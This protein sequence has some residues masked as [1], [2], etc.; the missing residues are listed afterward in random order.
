MTDVRMIVYESLLEIE[1]GQNI[2]DVG[3]GTLDKHAY[4]DKQ[5]R[6]FMHCLFEG[7]IDKKITLDYVIDSVSKMPVSKM[8][9]PVK[10]L[11]RMGAYQ[12]LFM[13]SVPDRASCNET[14]AIARKKHLDSL[15]GFINGVLRSICRMEGQ[16]TYPDKVRDTKRYLSV[17]YSMPEII[18]ESLIND[19]GKDE[20]ERILED[21]TDN[22][23]IIARVLKS[24]TDNIDIV[25]EIEK[26]DGIKVHRVDDMD[27]FIFD[28]LTALSDIP[29]FKTGLFTIQ[30]LSSQLV[31]KISGIKAGDIVLDVC[32]SPGGKSI[33]AADTLACL[34]KNDTGKK[35]KVISCDITENKVERI[36]ENIERCKLAN[37]ATLVSDATI[38][39]P[40]LDNVADVLICDVPC[41]GLGV[42]ARKRDIKYG[43]TKESMEELV[44]LQRRIIDN[45]ISYLKPG[46]TL[47]YSTCT[48][49][50]SEN[51]NQV[52]YIKKIPGIESVPFDE[53]LPD[54]FYSETSKEGYLQL[55]TGRNNTD[56]FFIAKFRKNS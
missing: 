38:H 46:G 17:C 24:R 43:L 48:M 52:Q 42:I 4:L 20:C 27:A 49:K 5:Q 50:K 28:E 36:D 29:S 44:T 2:R 25:A 30:D 12:I 34:E 51:N 21:M 18:I 13:D 9:K 37:I 11:L 45:V 6:A 10:T 33:A 1:K 40:D 55:F 39:N 31:S 56:G 8:K 23:P 15:S 41:S 47:V 14:V 54:E 3:K 16:I 19:Y 22:R 32:A 26:E 7:V 53:L 35:G